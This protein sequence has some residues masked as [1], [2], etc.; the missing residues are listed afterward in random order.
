MIERAHNKLASEK[1]LFQ[2]VACPV[3]ERWCVAKFAKVRVG[4][5][6]AETPS[7]AWISKT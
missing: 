5:E 1:R 7:R 2:I 3:R 6:D 4:V